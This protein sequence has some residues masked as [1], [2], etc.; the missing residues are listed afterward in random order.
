MK[1]ETISLRV[2]GRK[3]TVTFHLREISV[4]EDEEYGER[5]AK[6]ADKKGAEKAK[7]AF[8]IYIDA[9]ASWSDAMPT[10]ENGEVDE[11]GNAISLPIGEGSI[12]DAVRQYFSDDSPAKER[13]LRAVIGNYRTSL[14]PD[15]TF[16]EHSA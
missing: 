1:Q 5:H 13:M 15:V 8:K 4:S 12:S 11:K 16:V 9:I 6:I 10:I 7:A 3:D 14:Y 2:V